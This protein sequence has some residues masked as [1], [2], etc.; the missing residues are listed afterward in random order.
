[1]ASEELHRLPKVRFAFRTFTCMD[2]NIRLLAL[3][4]IMMCRTLLCGQPKL[5]L[6]ATEA[7]PCNLLPTLSSSVLVRPREGCTIDYSSVAEPEKASCYW[8]PEPCSMLRMV[9]WASAREW[10]VRSHDLVFESGGA[11]FFGDVRRTFFFN[12]LGTQYGGGGRGVPAKLKLVFRPR[13]R[14]ARV[15]GRGRGRGP[16]GAPPEPESV[17]RGERHRGRRGGAGAI[18]LRRS[19]KTGSFYV[20]R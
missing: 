17:G 18:T 16:A 15:T 1:M 5:R 6:F 12:V 19:K 14:A 2:G 3:Y 7:P 9:P 8:C 13:E 11:F 20:I 4:Y 10:S